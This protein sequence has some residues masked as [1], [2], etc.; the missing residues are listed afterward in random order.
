MSI[1]RH[2]Y[3]EF[4]ILYLD[5]ELSSEDRRLVELF[6]QQHPD[7]GEE[8]QLLEQTRLE[9]DPTII[10]EAKES[11]MKPVGLGWINA[12]NQEEWLVQYIDNELINEQKAAVEIYVANNP[13]VKAEL[14]VLLRTKLRPE[15]INFPNKESLYRRE[16]SPVL[17]LVPI[18][19]WRVAAAVIL[20]IALTIGGIAIFKNNRT[21]EKGLAE[22]KDNLKGSAPANVKKQ[23][24]DQTQSPTLAAVNTD[25]I[26]KEQL[27]KKEI[28]ETAVKK[29]D[30]TVKPLRKSVKEESPVIA[31]SDIKNPNNLPDVSRN[32]NINGS[33]KA[34]ATLPDLAVN[35]LTKSQENTSPPLVTSG[36]PQSFIQ[37]KNSLTTDEDVAVSEP[38]KKTKFR[39]LLRTLTRTF[40]KTTNIKAT[41][42]DDRL[43]VAG[44]AI[45][46]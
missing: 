29:I 20:L 43:L 36:T 44:L 31:S 15:G 28:N 5:N 40:E 45:R 1:N 22:T 4:F 9:L 12:D 21:P 10:F 17:R 14:E 41:D 11:L 42:D 35:G 32:P 7:L 34:K 33:L 16:K 39:G 8:L 25:Q 6:V 13:S 2:N 30:N 27:S 3:E 18:R 37:A 26:K 19:L 38:E 24:V 23:P 46:L